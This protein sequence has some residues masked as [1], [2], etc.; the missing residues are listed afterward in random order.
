[1]CPLVLDEFS[2]GRVRV[3]SARPRR[4]TAVGVVSVFD[5]NN[6]SIRPGNHQKKSRQ[7]D[8]DAPD[9]HKI[10]L[11]CPP[12]LPIVVEPHGA[13]GLKR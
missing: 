2:L 8:K 10:P 13:E 4:G 3:V 7:D 1:M 5:I 11:S 6:R 12:I 9:H